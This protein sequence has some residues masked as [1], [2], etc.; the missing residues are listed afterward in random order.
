LFGIP[1]FIVAV[2]FLFFRGNNPSNIS[3]YEIWRHQQDAALYG[4]NTSVTEAN[5][6]YNNTR[7]PNSMREFNPQVITDNPNPTHLNDGRYIY[8]DRVNSSFETGRQ[9]NSTTGSE[10]RSKLGKTISNA[11]PDADFFR[12]PEAG[13]R[14]PF[15]IE[16]AIDNYN[17]IANKLLEG[18]IQEFQEAQKLEEEAKAGLVIKENDI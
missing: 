5:L 14:R 10:F 18:P 2:N 9:L 3:N 6:E 1:L 8:V 17:I 13:K 7:N 4:N 15:P 12:K 16:I 11:V